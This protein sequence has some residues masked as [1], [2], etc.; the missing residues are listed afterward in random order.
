MSSIPQ[1]PKHVRLQRHQYS[2]VSADLS[3]LFATHIHT[4][5]VTGNIDDVVQKINSGFDAID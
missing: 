4:Q 3:P 2:F 1:R 5:L